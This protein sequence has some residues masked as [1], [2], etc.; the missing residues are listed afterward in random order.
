M[1][2]AT[3]S[4]I[5]ARFPAHLSPVIQCKK[6]TLHRSRI[7]FYAGLAISIIVS[8]VPMSGLTRSILL[9]FVLGPF[10]HIVWRSSYSHGA[11]RSS[12]ILTTIFLTGL[13]VAISASL[14]LREYPSLRAAIGSYINSQ[15]EFSIRIG[16]LLGGG[17][18]TLVVLKLS[19]Y[20]G[21]YL[22]V[23]NAKVVTARRRYAETEKGWLDYRLESEEASKRLHAVMARLSR[24]MG[25]VAKVM[26]L[27]PLLVGK[28]GKKPAIVRAQIAASFITSTHGHPEWKRK[29]MR[30][31]R[32]QTCS[33]RV[34]RDCC[35]PLKS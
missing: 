13:Y 32:L 19:K 23:R 3:R 9:L 21:A 22:R 15:V 20:L 12:K 27:F 26:K 28:E 34:R 8:V 1:P 4:E 10:I 25:G 14:V 7:E 6:A 33:L 31:K 2:T 18:I 24:A 5:E 17:L 16:F 35:E 30:W 11:S 29:S